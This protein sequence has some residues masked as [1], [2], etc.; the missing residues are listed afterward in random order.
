MSAHILGTDTA[1]PGGI[2]S[3]HSYLHRSTDGGSKWERTQVLLEGDLRGDAADSSGTTTDRN[4]VEFPDGT[5]L[6]GVALTASGVA[7][8]WRSVDN[9]ITWQRDRRC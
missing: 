3:F 2:G 4:V 5:L 9:G 6:F 8:M 1:Y 7:Y